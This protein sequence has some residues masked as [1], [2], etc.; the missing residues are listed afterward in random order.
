[1]CIFSQNGLNGGSA[2]L[3]GDPGTK[4]PASYRVVHPG[5]IRI[6]QPESFAR[7]S[8]A[9]D[10]D[11]LIFA[12]VAHPPED[13]TV[14]DRLSCRLRP[15]DLELIAIR[16]VESSVS[17]HLRDCDHIIVLYPLLLRK[18]DKHSEIISLAIIKREK[19]RNEN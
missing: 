12:G 14:L 6:R 8:Q 13:L 5:D 15:G 2:R 9:V 4:F 16:V 11:K 17:H 18:Y 1:M 3:S 10:A 7:R 19:T